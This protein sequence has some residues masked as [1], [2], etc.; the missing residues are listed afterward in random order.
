VDA[1]LAAPPP[2][3]LAEWSNIVAQKSRG[4]TN[5]HQSLPNIK[6]LPA[7]TSSPTRDPPAA[8]LAFSAAALL[9][10]CQRLSLSCSPTGP[11]ARPSPAPLASSQDAAR[12]DVVKPRKM[13]VVS[14]KKMGHTAA[15]KQLK[16]QPAKGAEKEAEPAPPPAASW[17]SGAPSPR[18]IQPPTSALPK[19]IKTNIT[20]ALPPRIALPTPRSSGTA[21]GCRYAPA[22]ITAR[23]QAEQV[24]AQLNAA[25]E[26]RD[27]GALQR[28]I[29]TISIWLNGAIGSQKAGPVQAAQVRGGVWMTMHRQPL[30]RTCSTLDLIPRKHT[31]TFHAALQIK[32]RLK[33]ARAFLKQLA[34][35]ATRPFA[36]QGPT[37]PAHFYDR[38]VVQLA[39]FAPRKVVAS[40][41]PSHS[42]PAKLPAKL[43]PWATAAAAAAV[44]S[45]TSPSQSYGSGGCSSASE[46]EECGNR[47]EYECMV[48]MDAAPTAS[49]L[50]PPPLLPP[51]P[52]PAA[53]RI[54]RVKR[55]VLPVVTVHAV[56]VPC[57]HAKCCTGCAR[58]LRAQGQGEHC[59]YCCSPLECWWL[60]DEMVTLSGAPDA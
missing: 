9:G 32:T 31:L 58:A 11:W 33:D 2:D 55:S 51:P 46:T 37:Q 56:C 60:E 1:A 35:A 4:L 21:A 53:S 30:V 59:P 34:A 25:M 16:A 22:P 13:K 3:E 15:E 44:S 17:P 27:A 47:D 52:P 41:A 50:W 42:L 29:L 10:K 40:P 28:L 54:A 36:S 18:R 7:A 48:C 23:T 26:R 57:G 19:E 39:E 38:A 43:A 5:C 14:K 45:D 20:V 12:A 8:G 6:A 24:L 49:E